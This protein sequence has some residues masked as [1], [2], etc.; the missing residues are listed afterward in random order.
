[1]LFLPISANSLI[2]LLQ[3]SKREFLKNKSPQVY[4][5][6]LNSGK[7]NKSIFSF[8][9]FKICF[10]MLSKLL[11]TLKTLSFNETPRT[12]TN[13]KLFSLLLIVTHLVTS[14]LKLAFVELFASKSS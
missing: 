11:S 1:M 8:I 12:R 14:S 2:L 6:R 10:F 4:D 13:P 7:T 9:A 5:V 3:A